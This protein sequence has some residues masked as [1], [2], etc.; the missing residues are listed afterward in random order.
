M[1]CFIN[2]VTYF[3]YMFRPHIV[4]IFREV[5]LKDILH[6]TSNNL[7]YERKFYFDVFLSVHLSIFISVM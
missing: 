5:F 2:S 6:R 3:F 4:P 1:Y 7:I